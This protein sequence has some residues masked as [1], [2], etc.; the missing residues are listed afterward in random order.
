MGNRFVLIYFSPPN[1]V[2][3][4]L[5]SREDLDP[6]WDLGMDRVNGTSFGSNLTNQGN[7]TS[8]K[9]SIVMIAVT[10]EIVFPARTRRIWDEI[11]DEP[12]GLGFLGTMTWLPTSKNTP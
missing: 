8:S 5:C 1:T 2:T 3:K 4:S 9:D 10:D 6:E 11:V 12:L 7:L